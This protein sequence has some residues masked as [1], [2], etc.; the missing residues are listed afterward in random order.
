MLPWWVRILKSIHAIERPP[1]LIESLGLG[2]RE[3]ISLVGAGGKTTLMFRLA[4]E[5][6]HRGEKGRHNHNDQDPGTLS[7]GVSLPFCRS[8]R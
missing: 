6:V 7:G 5:L 8:G 2:K 4:K 3:M 1:S